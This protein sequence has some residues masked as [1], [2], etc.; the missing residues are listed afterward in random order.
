MPWSTYFVIGPLYNELYRSLCFMLFIVNFDLK[1][2]INN[3][4][5]NMTE[6]FLQFASLAR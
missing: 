1:L 3:N 5:Y 6:T 2:S 4:K